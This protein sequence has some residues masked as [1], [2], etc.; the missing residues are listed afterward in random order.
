MKS[1]KQKKPVSAL[2]NSICFFAIL[3]IIP[4]ATFLSP[5]DDFLETENR[6]AAKPPVLSLKSIADKS[7][8][9]D[10]EVYLSDVI[11]GREYFVRAKHRLD[12]LGGKFEINGV[13]IL[14]SRMVERIDEPDYASI[15]RTV[16]AIN[17]F[18]ENCDIPIY[19]MLAPTS[20][21]VYSDEI[22]EFAPSL[23][24]KEF[25]DYVYKNT[26]RN[27]ANIDVYNTLHTARDDYIYYRTDHHW[28]TYGAYLAYFDAGRRLGLQP[29]SLLNYNMEHAGFDFRGTFYNRTL[30]KATP[31][32]TLTLYHSN[33]NIKPSLLVFE[34][35]GADALYYESIYFRDF[36]EQSDKYSVFLGHNQPV[37]TIIN[38]NPNG[39]KLLMIKDSYAHSVAPFLADHY[40]ETTLLDLRYISVPIS[41]I[42][43]MEEYDQILILYNVATF[44]SDINLRKLAGG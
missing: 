21:G 33:S 3:I 28:T 25:I 14:K 24:Q 32:D 36:L 30:H 9:R 34:E 4:A 10:F 2:L 20:A 27:I 40:S 26:S 29:A 12:I 1:V 39:G 18:A 23:N 8:M 43:N 5:K 37:V 42:V 31:A 44:T 22:P 35:V 38:G 13:Y 15:D 11:F 6:A 19:F 41:T 7:F 16:A 17:K